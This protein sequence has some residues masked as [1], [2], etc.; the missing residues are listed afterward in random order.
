MCGIA[1]IVNYHSNETAT[2]VVETMLDLMAH[3]GP[4]ASGIYHND[5]VTL[6]HARLSIIDLSADG[7]QPIH[8]EDRSV[9]ITFNG[10]IFNYPELRRDLIAGGHRFYTQ[11]DTEVLV[12]L[13]EQYGTDMFAHLN[14]QFA[15]AIWDRAKQS[16][17]LAR[18]RVG[19]RPLFYH[20]SDSRLIFSSEIKALFADPSISRE[21]D[22]ATL[23]DIFTCWTATGD[24]TP[25]IGVQQL[26]PGHFAQFDQQGLRIRPYWTLPFGAATDETKSVDEWVEEIRALLLDATRI[27]LRADV[28][29][30]AYLSGGIDSTYTSTVVKRNFNNRLHT[31]SVGFTDPRFDEASFQEIAVASLGTEHRSVRCAEA[32]IGRIFP[33]VVWHAE[34]P[35]LRSLERTCPHRADRPPGNRFLNI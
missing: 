18:D 33:D 14:G 13:Y 5:A 4:D 27:R 22:P 31:F 17:L 25:F 24:R 7:D 23:S 6:G 16:L 20:Q 9:W 10:E 32:D 26:P 34:T 8:N 12:H 29:V 11:T 19:I 3:R 15:F 30:G 28:P 1:G 2:P 35:L 21:L